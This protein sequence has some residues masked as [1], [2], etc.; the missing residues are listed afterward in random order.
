[1][2]DFENSTALYGVSIK[3]LTDKQKRFLGYWS[4]HYNLS[5][6]AKQA[7]YSQYHVEG[8]RLSKTPKIRELMTQI[9][10]ALDNNPQ[11]TLGEVTHKIRL[12]IHRN[13]HDLGD[14]I[15]LI[16]KIPPQTFA[17]IDGI[18]I[19]PI[20]D[21]VKQPDGTYRKE[22]IDHKIKIKAMS[23]KDAYDIAMKYLGGYSPEITQTTIGVDW[24]SY[25][26]A[27]EEDETEVER[28]I[29]RLD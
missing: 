5:W 13:W 23:A 27:S 16:N 1:M 6:A 12:C 7:G 11:L 20:Y 18:S 10:E 9:K 3:H 19:E 2:Y 28:E 8:H 24:S 17:W 26:N 21:T 22:L 4:M 25:Q 29:K 14:V 15:P